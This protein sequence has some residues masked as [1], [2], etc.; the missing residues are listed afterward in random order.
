MCKKKSQNAISRFFLPQTTLSNASQVVLSQ[1]D[2]NISGKF[3][4]EGNV[5]F[6]M[7]FT[8]YEDSVNC[9][10]QRWCC[11]LSDTTFSVPLDI[12]FVSIAL[13]LNHKAVKNPH[14]FSLSLIQTVSADAPH[15][16]T[17]LVS[18]D[19]QVVGEFEFE[20]IEMRRDKKYRQTFF[21][22]FS[23][24][25]CYVFGYFSSPLVV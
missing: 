25:F 15:F 13:E 23:R 20:I 3:S 2:T 14:V 5:M 7:K 16:N 12:S 21:W 8:V 10:P 17:M 22:H 24:S 9:N 6:I 11:T 19:M 4:C 18:G 1:V